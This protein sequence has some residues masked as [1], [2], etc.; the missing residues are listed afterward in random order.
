MD[1]FLK[2]IIKEAGVIALGYYKEGIK[3][4]EKS[5]RGDVVTEADTEVER[6]LMTNILEKYPDHGILGEEK[7]NNVNTDAEY[8]WVIDPIDGTRNFA[9]HI[10]FWCTMIGVE[11]DGKPYMGAVYDAINDE[12]YYAKVGEGAFV[13][14]RPIKVSDYDQVEHSFLCYSGGVVDIDS[15]YN[16][17][18]FEEYKKF[19]KNL[20]D[21]KGHWVHMYGSVLSMCHLATGRIDC[22]L[23]NCGLYHDYLASYVITTEA[24]ANFTDCEGNDWEKG[25]RDIV[26]ANPKLHPKLLKLFE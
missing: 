15:P 10:A 24:G 20:C 19:H 8:V 2:K 26:V 16:P 4:E 18:K 14:D 25:G 23:N 13:N 17:E 22:Y 12:L 3:Y 21:T 6:F 7:I 11:K 1:E 5:G 9:N